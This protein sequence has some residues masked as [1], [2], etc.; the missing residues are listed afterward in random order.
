MAYAAALELSQHRMESGDLS[1][2]RSEDREPIA[3]EKKANTLP[4]HR[5]ADQLPGNESAIPG[6]AAA[7]T[8]EPDPTDNTGREVDGSMRFPLILRGP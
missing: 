3:Q 7:N 5:L 2:Q 8:A 4:D 1:N 6:S